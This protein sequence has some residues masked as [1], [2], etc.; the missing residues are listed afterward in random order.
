MPPRQKPPVPLLP[1]QV[2]PIADQ[3][4]GL[5]GASIADLLEQGQGELKRFDTVM[6]LIEA[7]TPKLLDTLQ[8]TL[9]NAND[10]TV[11]DEGVA[12]AAFGRAA[13]ARHRA[14]KAAL[15]AASANVE[16]LS[17]T[18][19]G[20]AT[21]D[22]KKV[23]ALLDQFQSTSVALNRS[24]SAL[25]DLATDPRLKANVF[26]TT[27]S[28]AET[29]QNAGGADERSANRDRRSA[30]AGADAQHDRE[31]RCGHAE[32]ELAARA[33]RRHEQRLR[34]RHAA[35]RRRR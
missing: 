30:D 7:R 13:R 29:T 12:A 25:Q 15:T 35:R 31:P 10:L 16:Q 18:L 19:N 23:G 1:R 6:S 21:T 20:A 22:S 24:M 14:S 34:S 4:R 5:N 17:A 9:N 28:I 32:G 2:L 3:P 27:Q 33:T 8:T 26:A 11:S